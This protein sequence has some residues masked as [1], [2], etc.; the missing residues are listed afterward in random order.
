MT[1]RHEASPWEVLSWRFEPHR[2]RIFSS[3]IFVDCVNFYIILSTYHVRVVSSNINTF[4]EKR[5]PRSTAHT[6][7]SICQIY[8]EIN[9]WWPWGWG[10][11]HRLVETHKLRQLDVISYHQNLFKT[12]FFWM[13]QTKQEL[14]NIKI[15]WNEFGL[16]RKKI[17]TSWVFEPSTSS[18]SENVS[19]DDTA[20][21][22]QRWY[23]PSYGSC[24]FF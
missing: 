15:R 11:A 1:K 20:P 9:T 16:R 10:C 6:V 3:N 4:E 22:Y 14:K 21:H 24:F 18:V 8:S 17:R 7:F 13:R 23:W 2:V 19:R 12:I 5:T